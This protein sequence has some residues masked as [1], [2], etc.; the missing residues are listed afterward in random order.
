MAVSCPIR[1]LRPVV[2]KV[3]IQIILR[4][5][6]DCSIHTRFNDT[7]SLLDCVALNWV[8]TV[9]DKLQRNKLTN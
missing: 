3:V 8:G 1:S 4:V 9:N 6:M 5:V 7:L 2:S